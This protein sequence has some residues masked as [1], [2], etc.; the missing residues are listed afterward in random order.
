MRERISRE[1]NNNNWKKA[2]KTFLDSRLRHHFLIALIPT[3]GRRGRV[4][5]CIEKELVF[6]EDASLLLDCSSL[7]MKQCKR[8]GELLELHDTCRSRA[9][10]EINLKVDVTDHHHILV[11]LIPRS[12]KYACCSRKNSILLVCS[13]F[14]ISFSIPSPSSLT[15]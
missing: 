11:L 12:F 13:Q 8:T 6:R 10:D 5:E 9:G 2:G 1:N 15:H 3:E 7:I 4:T 14:H